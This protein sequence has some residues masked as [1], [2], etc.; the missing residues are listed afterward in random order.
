MEEADSSRSKAGRSKARKDGGVLAVAWDRYL[1]QLEKR[2]LETKALTSAGLAGLSDIVAQRIVSRGVLNWRRT[3][4]MALFGL[5]WS[6]PSMHFWQQLQERIFKGR[7]DT[8]TLIK[9]VLLDQ[10]TFGPLSN[11]VFM[12]YIALVVEGRS[13]D[14]TKA[15]LYTDFSGV[16][17]NGWRLWPLASWVTYQ[18]IP[19]RLRV[20]FVNVVAFFW[21]T[22]LNYSSRTALTA[23]RK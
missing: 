10:L 9:R 12:S 16:Q 5:V 3:A 1:R 21:S 15:K 2:P 8:A 4:A 6:G 20:L 19:L 18:Y 22:F 11:A 14:F 17:K 13:F 23:W 7:R